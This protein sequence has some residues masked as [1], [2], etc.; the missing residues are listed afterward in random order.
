MSRSWLKE[1]PLTHYTKQL[2]KKK[3]IRGKVR[4]V[5]VKLGYCYLSLGRIGVML[6]PG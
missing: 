1:P 6:L 2:K 3:K 5:F 4:M